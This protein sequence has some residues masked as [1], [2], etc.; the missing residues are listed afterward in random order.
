MPCQLTRIVRTVRRSLAKTDCNLHTPTPIRRQRPTRLEQTNCYLS[1][2][3][4]SIYLHECARSSRAPARQP[5]TPVYPH[6]RPDDVLFRLLQTCY[7]LFPAHCL[8]YPQHLQPTMC[9]LSGQYS[10]PSQ[11]SEKASARRASTH[12]HTHT[13]IYIYIYMHAPTYIY[14]HSVYACTQAKPILT[15]ENEPTRPQQ[16]DAS[17]CMGSP[18]QIVPF[19][20]THQDR[21]PSKQRGTIICMVAEGLLPFCFCLVF[22]SGWN[23]L[24]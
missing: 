7:K 18:F 20:N 21:K 14:I 23:A 9:I 16:Q 8:V 10:A 15:T 24:P 11:L 12:T 13:H 1:S 5:Q 2:L 17:G 22:W 6:L 3:H 4:N 19:W